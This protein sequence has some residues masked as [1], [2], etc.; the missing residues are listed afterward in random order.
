[1]VL[2][3]PANQNVHISTL[4]HTVVREDDTSIDMYEY[5]LTRN[6]K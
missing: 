3:V 2:P 6:E 4:N 1:M 5:I